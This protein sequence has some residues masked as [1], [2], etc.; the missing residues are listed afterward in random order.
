M[1]ISLGFLNYNSFSYIEK[2]LENDY[3]TMSNGIINE[4]VIQ[5]D[6]SDHDYDKLKKRETENVKVFQNEKRIKPLLGR[7]N[8]LNN[9]TNDW[10]LVMDCDNFL[11]K[12]SFSALFKNLEFKENTI[13]A[14][15]FARPKFNFKTISDFNLDL[16]LVKNN[17][18]F[19]LC[20][21]NVG[22][23]LVPKK[24][25]LEV[26]KNI[27]YKFVEYTMEVLYYNYLWLSSGNFIKCVKGYEYDHAM[28][29]DCFSYSNDKNFNDIFQTLTQLYLK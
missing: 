28:R 23:Y 19:L 22:N 3:F 1:N 20:F 21:L 7:I 10:V 13:Y 25:Y 9:C 24:R 18:Q 11:D 17:L 16:N 26:A 14:P 27:D 2:Q 29:D 6:F 4:I 12:N 5:D 15:D 8:L